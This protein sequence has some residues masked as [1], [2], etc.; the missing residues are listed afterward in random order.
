MMQYIIWSAQELTG[1]AGRE[2]QPNIL[3]RAG[4]GCAA[5][6]PEIRYVR[7]KTLATHKKYLLHLPK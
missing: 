2:T 3:F 7:E 6:S 4:C 1:A 5:H